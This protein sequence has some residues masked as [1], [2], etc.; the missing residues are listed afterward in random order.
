MQR[1]KADFGHRNYVQK[2]RERKKKCV[3]LNQFRRE[4]G[5]RSTRFTQNRRTTYTVNVKISFSRAT[6]AVS[7]RYYATRRR[8]RAN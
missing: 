4:S 3:Y 7:L 2:D 5:R 6:A 1:S 8:S